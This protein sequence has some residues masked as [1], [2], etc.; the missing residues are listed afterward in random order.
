MSLTQRWAALPGNLR[1]AAWIVLASVAFTA[2]AACIKVIG[3]TMS[4]WE[5]MVLR[6]GLATLILSPAILRTGVRASFATQRPGTHFFRALLGMGGLTGFFFALTH[7]DLALVTTLGFTRALFVLLLAMLFLSEVV[8]WRRG[9]ATAVGFVGVIVCVQPGSDTFSIWTLVA[10]GSALCSA[11]VTAT[12]KRL[13]STERPLTIV[14]WSYLV[15]GALAAIPAIL[16]WQT[17]TLTEFGLIAVMAL[18]STAGQT[19]MVHGLRAGDASA[20]TPFE[21]TRLFF[22]AIV[23]YVLFAEVPGLHTWAGG[24]I[25]IAS[26]VYIAWRESQLRHKRSQPSS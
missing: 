21:Y 26:T 13:T 22:A 18:L 12:I 9:T 6:A 8:G 24:G 25:I 23:G 16:T 7:L 5:M 10:L 14:I 4:V 11:G 1:G 15:M 19:C 17:P 3:Q 2:M 20:V